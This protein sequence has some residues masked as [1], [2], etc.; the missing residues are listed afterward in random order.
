MHYEEALRRCRHAAV[1]AFVSGALTAGVVLFAIFSGDGGWSGDRVI[2]F[3]ADPWML[4]DVVMILGLGLGVWFRSRFC[5]VSLLI[6]YVLS[7][8][9]MVVEF[10]QVGGLLVSAIFVWF[11][12]RG[13]TG[14]F[15]AH[16]IRKERDENYRR[17]P[18]WR[19]IGGSVAA[20]AFL[21]LFGFGFFLMM[22]PDAPQTYVTDIDT[23]PQDQIDGLREA[24]IIRADEQL[25]MFYSEAVFDYRKAGNILTDS[26]V[27]SY[28]TLDGVQNIY[29]A[30]Y[31]EITGIYLESKGHAMEDTL[32]YITY[33]ENEDGWLYL[34]LSAERGGD[35][36]F[37]S[38]LARRT[39][40][41]LTDQ[42][43]A[44]L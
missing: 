35:E 22:S 33:G 5:A 29:S 20:V 38:Y 12:W 36:D 14:A 42:N 10:G 34:I 25:K 16:R 41:S 43:G 21:G 19:W 15:A 30:T 1:A 37:L 7:K 18:A 3:F 40:L 24:G 31:E 27:V 11:Y 44:P 4:I 6:Y 9:V 2:D 8:I 13:I 32:A 39:G 26:R 28:E 17:V 23:T